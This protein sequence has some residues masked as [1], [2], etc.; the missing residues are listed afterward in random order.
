MTRAE[1]KAR[2]PEFR[3]ASDPLVQTALD[4]AAASLNLTQFGTM[5][6][7]VLALTAADNLAKSPFGTSVRVEIN[8][9]GLNR[10]EVEL[11]EIYRATDVRMIVL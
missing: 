10:Y 2:H 11:A 1:F 9:K 4:D 8:D 3:A 6:T 7:R 5:A